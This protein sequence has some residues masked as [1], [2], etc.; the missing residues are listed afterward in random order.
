VGGPHFT[1]ELPWPPTSSGQF[2]NKST[3]GR[4]LSR[5][6]RSYASAVGDLVL[7][8]LV[9]R[10][11]FEG[12]RL[13]CCIV[14]HEPDLRARDLDNLLKAPLDALKKAGVIP[15]DSKFDL[16]R[17]ARGSV[18]ANGRLHIQLYALDGTNPS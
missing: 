2:V 11:Q 4:R 14:A 15:D 7:Q 3:G 16:L 5:R 13:A 9:P 18:V 12:M 1:F 17:I 10:F 6:G 8:G